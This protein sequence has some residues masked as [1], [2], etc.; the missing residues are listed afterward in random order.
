[1][2]VVAAAFVLYELQAQ[3]LLTYKN[4]ISDSA[5]SAPSNHTFHFTTSVAIP[6]A[7]FIEVQFPD[8]FEV[9]ASSTFS[10]NR[11]V[12]LFVNGVPRTVSDTLT[13]VSDRAQIF[14][15]APGMVRY[16]L[17]TISGIAAGSRLELRIGNNTTLA[18]NEVVFYDEF[19]DATTT[20]PADIKP[21]INASTTG[22]HRIPVR[23]F[24][25]GAISIG[26]ADF[27]IFLL[28][29][30]TIGP[31]D[32]RETVPPLRFNGSPE[33]TLS[34]L[35][36]F[37]E[38]SLET[39]EFAIC[40]FSPTPDVPFTSMTSTFSNTG[41]IFHSTL[42]PVVQNATTT[43]HVRCIDDEGNFN[44][45]DYI[46]TFFVQASPTGQANE[47]GD[48]SGDGSGTGNSGSGD[49][50]GAGGTTGSADGEADTTG[51]TAGGGGTGGGS[52]G[53]SGSSSGGG[54]SG[55]G[56]GGGGGG[57]E[58]QPGAFESGDGRVVIS[59]T[60]PAN[61]RLFVLVD[62][63]ERGNVLVNN[64]GGYQV[65]ID[66]ISRGAYTFGIYAIDSNSVR[67]STF[68]TSFTVQGARASA[69][70]NIHIPPSVRVTPDPVDPGQVATVSG[71]SV[72]GATV[73]IENER[74][75]GGGK[76][77]LT[78]TAG[79]TG[80]WSIPVD[81][82]GFRVGTYRVRARAVAE[83]VSTNFSNYLNYGVGERATPTINADLNRD[84]RVNLTDFSILLFWWGTDGG[85]SN[86]PADINQ[87]GR[88]NL[89]DFSILLF[90][91][92]G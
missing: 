59:G 7:G 32:T 76:Q 92:T 12:Q 35:A 5:P 25:A 40:R 89:T 68:S 88:V 57:F 29:R 15:G 20:I 62:G 53:G 17:N 28:E 82:T 8:T 87:D 83:G 18:Q 75:D 14:P 84:G 23:L 81:T 6:P 56:G 70:S 86:P 60:A 49:G 73:T 9:M 11:N 34:G 67:T 13:G 10:P 27:V 54:S 51:G 50:S 44:I 1:M 55:G 63:R 26:F 69:L 4:V 58:S 42:A 30:V 77:T 38:V 2:A 16:T 46:I 19:L 39:N 47:D 52:G 79:A 72:P 80:A 36:L 78:A 45:D 24:N 41:L 91:W 3:Q 43:L 90:N 37:I 33:G 74:A 64:R 61:S 22:M 31:A 48:T 85:A 66:G 71:F 21:V 65:T